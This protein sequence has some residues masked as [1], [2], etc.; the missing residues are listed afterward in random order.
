MKR[1]ERPWLLA[2]SFMQ[3]SIKGSRKAG[4]SLV[5]K[6]GERL[7]VQ[8]RCVCLTWAQGHRVDILPPF[9]RVASPDPLVVTESAKSLLLEVA[10][11]G[12]VPSQPNAS[13]KVSL[14]AQAKQPGAQCTAGTSKP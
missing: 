2:C 7:W 11:G 4:E 12:A 8:K 9:G 10:P 14:G 5:E 1:R 13:K 6:D 3:I